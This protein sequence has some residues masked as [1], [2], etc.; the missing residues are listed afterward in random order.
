M[1]V[2]VAIA[3]IALFYAVMQVF[4]LPPGG[5]VT[6]DQGSKYLQTRA[7]ATDGPVNPSIDVLARDIDPEYR[8][9]EPKLK[10][11]GGRLV[12]E[13]LWLLPLA[14]APFF[15]LFGL[16]GL[17][18]VP[19]LSAIGIFLAAAALGRRFD[20]SSSGAPAGW[21]ALLATPV[22]LY[23][24][25]FWE[26]APAVA[27]VMA[28]AVLLFPEAAAARPG[29]ERPAP[30]LR[31][32]A[33]G[34]LIAAGA[35][36]REEV[37]AALPALVAGRAIAV[38]SARLRTLLPG[39]LWTSA[40][41]ALVFVASI[42]VNL[43]M[44]GAP[45]PMHM[46]QDAWQVA[47]NTPYLSVRRDI[48]NVWLLPG[49]YVVAFVVAAAAGLAASLA[50]AWRRRAD[51]AREHDTVAAALLLVVHLAAIVMLGAG[52]GSPL[53][54]LAHGLSVHH[55]YNVP[56]A[57]HTWPFAVA[58]L[59][60]PW[61]I[62]RQSRPAA[63]FAIVSAVL[64]FV[65]TMLLVPT[66]GGSQ[67]SPRFLLAVVP[68]LAVVAAQGLRSVPRFFHT[69]TAMVAAILLASTVMQI[70]G[71]VWL[72]A[73]KTDTARL[74]SWLGE[75]TQPGDV[76]ISNVFWVPEVAATLAPT[77]RM[78]FSWSTADVPALAS[79]AAARGFDRFAIVTSITL[80]GYEAPPQLD[81]PGAPCRFT[82]GLRLPIKFGLVFSQYGCAG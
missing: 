62:G 52:V 32:A 47:V 51:A 37:I 57:A 27:C 61:F 7:F 66:D 63:R 18:V 65:A 39:T 8:H 53:W 21:V 12:S 80:T 79:L 4:V 68:L 25:E 41:A 14:S 31:L 71:I 34:A 49:Q 30:R 28:A 16:H 70:H 9:Q 59:Y 82:R 2:R 17:Y 64:L 5:W 54:R 15:G 78:L 35:L 76:I 46:T 11:R 56:S 73:A 33:A 38:P 58:V 6:G 45:L 43:M 10:N 22:A 40:G 48:V 72:R 13:F 55:S 26:H 75:L 29:A 24:M 36:F 3:A 67:W 77:R 42:P 23:G 20:G 19:A 81:V 69:V 60:A 74:A 1:P 50:Q 44:Y